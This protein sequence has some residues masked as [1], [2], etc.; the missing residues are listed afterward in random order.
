MKTPKGSPKMQGKA[1]IAI[2]SCKDFNFCVY[3]TLIGQFVYSQK[4][5]NI[6]KKAEKCN[7]TKNN[8]A[9]TNTN[10]QTIMTLENN[11]NDVICSIRNL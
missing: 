10:K 3:L 1:I 5:F 9:Y 2:H 6:I 7:D 11:R 4:S 8:A